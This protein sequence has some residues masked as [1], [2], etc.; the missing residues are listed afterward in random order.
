[1]RYAFALIAAYVAAMVVLAAVAQHL[2]RTHPSFRH[3]PISIHAPYELVVDRY[4]PLPFGLDGHGHAPGEVSVINAKD[5]VL[6]SE[7]I[8]NVF[9]VR[10]V[11]WEEFNVHF[12]FDQNGKTYE[13]TLVL[14]P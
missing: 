9:T 10:D 7:R 4:A 11:R 5:I 6:D 3:V 1:M 8:D 13:S 12:D 2:A 14:E